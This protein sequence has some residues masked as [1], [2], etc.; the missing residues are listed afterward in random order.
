MTRPTV[1]RASTRR[2]RTLVACALAAAA[3]TA[4]SNGVEAGTLDPSTSHGGELDAG[5]LHVRGAYVVVGEDGGEAVVT[6]TVANIGAEEDALTALSVDGA[7]GTVEATLRP[8]SI[9]LAPGTTTTFPSDPRPSIGID[10]DAPAGSYVSAT[11][12]F[13][14]AGTVQV[15]LPVVA[16][17][18][19]FEQY[20]G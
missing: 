5:D 15:D 16:A 20:A 6:L 9:P 14:Q 19:Y 1:S 3:L 2:P 11:M 13:E 4:C 17:T 12:I 10:V 18:G 7:E 8:G